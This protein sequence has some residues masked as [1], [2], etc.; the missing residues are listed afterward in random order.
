MVA[1]YQ[2]QGLNA[3][4]LQTNLEAAGIEVGIVTDDIR[5]IADFVANN[6]VSAC[7]Y[8]YE[9]SSTKYEQ[10]AVLMALSEA[11]IN[12]KRIAICEKEKAIFVVGG[13]TYP[14]D[15]KLIKPV[16]DEKIAKMIEQG[17]IE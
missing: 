7:L 4:V 13:P 6:A 16:T 14:V 12:T 15:Y 5:E 17:I 9:L 11:N 3:F 10:L 2:K 1:I 8:D